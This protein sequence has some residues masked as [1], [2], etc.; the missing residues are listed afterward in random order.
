[1]TKKQEAEIWQVY[2]TWLHSYTNGDVATYDSYFDDDYHFIGSTHNEE[3]LN[4]KD[5]TDFFKATASQLA[6]KT[7]L[8][9][10]TKVME[11]V[12]ELVMITHL[13]DGWFLHENEW[14]Y[15]GRFRFTSL[16]KRRA[17]GWRFIYQHFSTTD[18]KAESGETAGF[19]QVAAENQQLREAVRRRTIELEY[20][21]RE[22]EIEAALEKIRSHTMGMQ[23]SE[24]LKE[25]LQVVYDQLVDL[26]IEIEHAGFI[27]DIQA[28]DNMNIWL[29]DQNGAPSQIT[30]PYFD[31]PYWDSLKEAKE[32]GIHF[33]TNKL[34]FEEKNGFYRKLFT[35]L[36]EL[37]EEAKEFYFSCAGLAISTVLLDNVGLYIENVSGIPYSDAENDVLLRVGRVFQQSYT[38]FLDLQKAEA[39]AKEAQIEVALERVRARSMAMHESSEMLEVADILFHQLRS[40][41]GKMW[42]CGVMICQPDVDEDEAW[43]AHEKGIFPPV[44]IPHTEDPTHKRMYEGWKNKLELYSESKEGQELKEHYDYMLSVPSIKPHFEAIPASDLTFPAWQKWHAAYFSHGYLLIVTLEPYADERIFTRFAKVFDQAYIR[45]LDLQRAEAQSRESEIQLAL[46]RVRARMMAMQKSEDLS[47]VVH[48][49]Y[50]QVEALNIA[51]LACNIN[52][53]IEDTQTIECWMAGTVEEPLPKSYPLAG[54]DHP[55]IAKMWDSW[56]SQGPPFYIH[57]TGAAHEEYKN[58]LLETPGYKLLPEEFRAFIRANPEAYFTIINMPCGQIENVTTQPLSEDKLEVLKRFAAVFQQAY[59]RFLD[60]QKAEEQANKIKLIN[61]EN[62]RLLHSILPEQIAEQIRTGRQNVVKRFEQVS[63]LFADIV[64]F[65]VL[66]EKINPQEVVDIL[67]GLFSKFDDLTDRHGLEKIKTIGDAYMVAAGVPEEKEDHAQVI[68]SFAQA[69]LKTLQEYNQAMGSNLSIRIGISS[70]PVVAGVIGKKKFAYD[71]WGD[72]V[73]TAARMEAYGREGKIQLSPASY[74]LLKNDFAFEK[75]PNVLI[76]GKGMMDVYLWTPDVGA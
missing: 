75:I 29:A 50:R 34:S 70:G 38:R 65:T 55:N 68:F 67:N 42:A 48:I 30:I 76:K 61:Q 17:Q 8:R 25:L 11:T 57:S 41:G 60:L 53:F 5:T 72:S 54:I 27:I 39:Q 51:D 26:G 23:K 21:N 59:T 28:G 13:F 44:V 36:P 40:L 43:F 73:N 37:P 66:S 24:E 20:K 22:L 64:G 1:M 19:D 32:Q 46:E 18:S 56:R 31:S 4:R 45:F 6:G 10:E 47:E 15:Y 16:L 35:H 63:I 71:L 33:F 52:L 2:H 12:G 7:D 14:A 49:L 58:M 62:E 69:M 74:E 9:N 3:F